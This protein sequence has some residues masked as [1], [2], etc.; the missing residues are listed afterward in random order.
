[1]RDPE[2]VTIADRHDQYDYWFDPAL[3]LGE[4]ALVVVDDTYG[5]RQIAP[6]F[7][8]L[9]ELESVPYAQYGQTIYRPRIYLGVG[10]AIRGRW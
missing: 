5:T 7:E 10:F 6:Y 4:S 3:H 1:M 9:T 2:V 8:S